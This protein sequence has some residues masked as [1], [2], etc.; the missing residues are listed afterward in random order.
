MGW[1]MKT[2]HK[3]QW[4][5]WIQNTDWEL[6]FKYAFHFLEVFIAVGRRFIGMN[7]QIFTHLM[8]SYCIDL[9][10]DAIHFNKY[11]SLF[12]R[13]KTHNRDIQWNMEIRKQ[14]W[15]ICIQIIVQKSRVFLSKIL[16][17]HHYFPNTVASLWKKPNLQRNNFNLL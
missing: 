6:Q 11:W 13:T 9:N 4:T 2:A 16:I 12:E 1:R 14:R 8:L 17:F 3:F 5:L 10:Y 15:K 7:V